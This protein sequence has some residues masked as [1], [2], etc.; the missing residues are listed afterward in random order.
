MPPATRRQEA[1]TRAV[2]KANERAKVERKGPAEA[3]MGHNQPPEGLD[4]EKPAK[5]PEPRLDLKKRPADQEQAQSPQQSQGRERGDGG[6]FAP[7]TDKGASPSSVGAVATPQLPE[8]APYREPLQRMSERARQEWAAAPESVRGEVHR[9][10]RE[11]SEAYHRLKGDSD[12]FNTVRP[13]HEL[14]RQQG[15]TLH[16]AL[17]NYVG[18]EKRLREDPIGGLDTIVNNL[19]LRTS[20][21]HRLGL[22]DVAHHILSQSPEQLQIAQS[23]QQ[24]I[25]HQQQLAEIKREQA[26]LAQ[27]QQQMQY[28]QKFRQTRGAVNRFAETHPRLDELTP[29]IERELALGFD[30][31]TAYQRANLLHPASAHAAQTTP[32]AQ[33]RTRPQ[34]PQTR[35]S[36][37]SISGAPNGGASAANG[38]TRP[39]SKTDRRGSI[40][41]AVRRANGSL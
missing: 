29:A 16:H 25:A 38:A 24:Q 10:H 1:I 41:N 7:K 22:V 21:G 12:T 32:A 6:R 37:R 33:T 3:R 19:N 36:D 18:I 27:Q 14:A 39:R 8:T 34:A 35:T 4:A 15:T 9:M 17:T 2:D 11:F 20:D 40:V 13:Y 23:R 31:P 28:E 26:K 5:A 30:L